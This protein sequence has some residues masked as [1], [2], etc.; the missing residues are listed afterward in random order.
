MLNLNVRA[1]NFKY[2]LRVIALY[3]ILSVIICLDPELACRFNQT[4]SEIPKGTSK[5]VLWSENLF[6]F[7]TESK[8]IL[9]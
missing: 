6:R 5:G 9:S 4:S 2:F 8:R 1:G 3:Y 7:G